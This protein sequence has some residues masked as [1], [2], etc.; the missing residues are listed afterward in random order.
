MCILCVY[1]INLTK[2]YIIFRMFVV[3][4][5]FEKNGNVLWSSK[6]RRHSWNGHVRVVSMASTWRLRSPRRW[7]MKEQI[8][9]DVEHNRETSNGNSLRVHCDVDLRYRVFLRRQQIIW[10]SLHPCSLSDA[11]F[12]FRSVIRKSI[13][14]DSNSFSNSDNNEPYRTDGDTSTWNIIWYIWDLV[15]IL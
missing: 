11:I 9:K 3:I 4:Q 12:G 5:T 13:Q 10:Y 6:R 8:S 1:Y 14:S 15:G 7:I 2:I